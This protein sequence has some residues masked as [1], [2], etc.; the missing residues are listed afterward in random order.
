LG[1]NEVGERA[2]KTRFLVQ[3]WMRMIYEGAAPDTKLAS[4]DG[5]KLV[6]SLT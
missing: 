1:I 2:F 3:S 4:L 5:Q 6:R